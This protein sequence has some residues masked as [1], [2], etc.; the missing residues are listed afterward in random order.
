M[1]QPCLR[2]I[3]ILTTSFAFCAPASGDDAAKPLALEKSGEE[4]QLP[5]RLLGASA[6]ALIEHLID[7]PRK[8]AALKA[9]DL[10][11]VRFPGG[12]QSNFYNWRTGLLDMPA[13][14][15]SSAY[16]RF[17]AEIASKIRAGHPEGV[18][19]GAYTTF[20]RQLG[21]EVVFVPNLETSS[22]AEQVAWFR[23]MKAAGIAPRYVELGNEFWI[24]MGFDPDSLKRW[25]DEPSSMRIMKEYC[26][27]LR[28]YFPAGVRVAVQSAASAF[29]LRDNPTRPAGRRL[30]QWDLDLKPAPWFDAVTIHPYPRMDTI[31]GER[32]AAQG[33]HQPEKAMKL[34]RALLAHCDQGTDHV[35]EDVRQRLPGKEIWVTEWN[36]RG[37]DYQIKDE[38]TPA[39]HVQLASRMT[40]AMLRHR[41]VT[42]S[43]YFTLNFLRHGPAGGAFQSDTQG[44][45][46]PMPHVLALRWF[47]E[48]ANGGAIYQRFVESGARRTPGGGALSESYLE[49]EAGLFRKPTA[50]TLIIQ[51]CSAQG[52]V[53]RLPKSVSEKPPLR[54]ETLA[55]SNL[56]AATAKI[57][58]ASQSA[59]A[60]GN[61]HIPAY[62]ITRIIWK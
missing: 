23:H 57:T 7:D 53:F 20:A 13:T 37:A 52:R 34:F 49:I 27:A 31:M 38:P 6:E 55:T 11:F 15:R 60:G 2:L 61:I 9:M 1:K 29:W 3:W 59:D 5:E 39:M 45:Y 28:P 46:Q 18:K 48:A 41:E 32:G 17:W 42:M 43:L 21:A 24:A 47:H 54:I 33:W 12:S 50:E 40:F 22:V 30:R 26:D 36:T 62:S 51:N 14:P 19:I 16:M 25:P 10:A 4:R 44:G 8:V 56:T 35:V 58:P